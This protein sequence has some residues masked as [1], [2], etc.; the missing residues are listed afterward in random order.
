[1]QKQQFTGSTQA[2]I[3][4]ISLLPKTSATKDEG[5]T[6]DLQYVARV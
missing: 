6:R 5:P 4:G 1:M 2:I 3:S